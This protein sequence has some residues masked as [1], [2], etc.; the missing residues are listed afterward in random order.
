MKI[1]STVARY[2]LGLIFVCFGLNGFLQFLPA[3]PIPGIAGQFVGA[4]FMSH[5]LVAVMFIQLVG[6]I[7]LLANRYVPLALTILGAVIVNIFFFHAFMDPGG[8]PKAAVVIVLWLLVA[9]SARSAFAGLFQQRVNDLASS[10]SA[11]DIATTRAT[12]R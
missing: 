12:V 1:V 2:P 9:Y 11:T 10:K 4:L 8:L 6:G 5:Y 7:L 3:H